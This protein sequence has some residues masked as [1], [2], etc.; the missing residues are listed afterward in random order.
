M[1]FATVAERLVN[2]ALT[3]A[4][5]SRGLPPNQLIQR[6]N[7]EGE[8][9]VEVSSYAIVLSGLLAVTALAIAAHLLPWAARSEYP[10]Y[11]SMPLI[12]ATTFATLFTMPLPYGGA[13]G[14]ETRITPS[15]FLWQAFTFGPFLIAAALFLF[16]VTWRPAK[17][18]WLQPSLII[19]SIALVTIN[20][21]WVW[22]MVGAVD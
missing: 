11:V 17:P 1:H 8:R 12:V 9:A 5:G 13:L 21:P 6:G 16:A 19:A 20:I 10:A 14:I 3:I 2:P 15:T 18:S 22:G 4:F 7:L